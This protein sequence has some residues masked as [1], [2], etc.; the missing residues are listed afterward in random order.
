MWTQE[1]SLRQANESELFQE[2]YFTSFREDRDSF[3]L[4]AQHFLAQGNVLKGQRLGVGNNENNPTPCKGNI[5]QT[6]A[7]PSGRKFFQ[8][9][10]SPRRRHYMALP[11]GYYILGFQ[12]E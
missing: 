8:S 3:G 6:Y 2:N 1:L 4:K 5:K 10:F 11:L 12:P 9:Y 7:A